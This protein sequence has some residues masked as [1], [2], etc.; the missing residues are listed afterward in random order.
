MSS[1]TATVA[2]VREQAIDKMWQYL[3]TNFDNFSEANKIK[4]TVAI[5]AKSMPTI[6]EGNYNVTKMPSVKL[7]SKEQEINLG[8]RVAEYTPSTQSASASNHS[9]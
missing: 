3:Y 2:R 8:N 7:D 5:C 1:I 6:V 4:V 9:V